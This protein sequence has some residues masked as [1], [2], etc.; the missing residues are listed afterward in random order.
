VTHA[1]QIHDCI[2]YQT[3]PRFSPTINRYGCRVF[4]LLA[5]PQFIAGRCLS[6]KQIKDIIEQGQIQRYVIV[7]AQMLCG[8]D[9]HWLINEGFRALKIRRA[10]R[11]VG[12]DPEHIK[13]RRWQYMIA[14]WETAGPDGHYTL[15]DRGQKE[16]Y[17]PHDSRQA[18]Y[19]IDK[20][21]IVRRLLYSTWSV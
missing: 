7:N 18:G 13:T 16:I 15:F 8:A 14:H 4:T 21:Q 2:L 10:G 17:D 20:R 1:D 6:V 9:E 5:I 11:Q 12:W 19:T 3:D